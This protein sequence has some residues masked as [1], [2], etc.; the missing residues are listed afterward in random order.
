MW[1]FGR[2]SDQQVSPDGKTI[3]FG[4]KN[5]D[6]KANKGTNIIYKCD[7]NGGNKIAITNAEMNAFSARFTPD[8]KKISY[9]KY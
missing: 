7:I 4:V 5:Y 1:Q 6:I 8:G 3:I 9:L 2:V